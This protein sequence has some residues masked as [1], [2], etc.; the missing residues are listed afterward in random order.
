MP[1]SG[2]A[3]LIRRKRRKMLRSYAFNLLIGVVPLSEAREILRDASDEDVCRIIRAPHE[4]PQE[5]PSMGLP[6]DLVPTNKWIEVRKLPVVVC[7]V[8]EISH[9]MMR[10]RVGNMRWD[11]GDIIIRDVDGE[12]YPCTPGVFDQTYE[13]VNP[14]QEVGK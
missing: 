4:A 1:E 5:D 9:G 14:Q 8:R 11:P 10:T 3:Y 12:Q 7:A 2:I 13:I 6:S